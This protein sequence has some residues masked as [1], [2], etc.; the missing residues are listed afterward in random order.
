MQ[1]I[2]PIPGRF[3]ENDLAKALI[4]HRFSQEFPTWGAGNSC[5]ELTSY[6]EIAFASREFLARLFEG[7]QGIVARRRILVRSP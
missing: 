3:A 5:A 2:L 4:V 6:R 7:R 1:G